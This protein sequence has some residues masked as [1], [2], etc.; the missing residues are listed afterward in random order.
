MYIQIIEHI[1]PLMVLWDSQ[2]QHHSNDKIQI[3]YSAYIIVASL[4]LMPH[5]PNP[6]SCDPYHKKEIIWFWCHNILYVIWSNL[7]TQQWYLW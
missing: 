4:V 5:V 2:H 1:A 3:P 7:H 6:S